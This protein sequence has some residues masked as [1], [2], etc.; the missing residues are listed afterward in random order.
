MIRISTYTQIMFLLCVIYKCPQ[1]QMN[2]LL[3]IQLFTLLELMNNDNNK[4]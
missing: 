1:K 2:S 4:I 3:L